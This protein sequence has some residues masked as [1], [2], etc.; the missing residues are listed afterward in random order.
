MIISSSWAG[1]GTLKVKL[2]KKKRL[3]KKSLFL[4]GATATCSTGGLQKG[5]AQEN[6]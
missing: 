2:K 3:K 4:I 5:R 1:I 6:T